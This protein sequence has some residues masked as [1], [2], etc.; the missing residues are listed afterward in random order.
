MWGTS[1]DNGELAPIYGDTTYGWL[2]RFINLH[3]NRMLLIETG[4]R[5]MF[6]HFT[7]E[8]IISQ[9]EKF[10]R[11]VEEE[12]RIVRKQ[13]VASTHEL[14]DSFYAK[15][16]QGQR[17]R[18]KM[19]MLSRE[20]PDGI[21]KTGDTMIREKIGPRMTIQDYID[22]YGR[23]IFIKAREDTSRSS[24][25]KSSVE[26][27]Q[28]YSVVDHTLPGGPFETTVQMLTTSPIGDILG[29]VVPQN[30]HSHGCWNMEGMVIQLDDGFQVAEEI[31]VGELIGI[32]NPTIHIMYQEGWAASWAAR[33]CDVRT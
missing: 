14:F 30:E 2:Y 11:D 18:A 6:V 24:T 5:A 26:D 7:P 27:V 19:E 25:S 10:S 12:N 15:D 28:Q 4:W 20:R 3:G 23:D 32:R 9:K 33:R 1:G 16:V 8:K 29:I 31:P 17:D 22:K 13:Y 21:Y